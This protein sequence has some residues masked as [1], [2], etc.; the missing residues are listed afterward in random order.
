MVGS[1]LCTGRSSPVGHEAACSRK[2]WPGKA[3]KGNPM[4]FLQCEL[5]KLCLVSSAQGESPALTEPRAKLL[6]PVLG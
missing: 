6:L 4:A 2:G 1:F 3:A 5:I